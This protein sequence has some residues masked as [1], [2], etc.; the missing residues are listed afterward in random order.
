MLFHAKFV[1]PPLFQFINQNKG[2]SRR[3]QIFFWA[4]DF[5]GTQTYLRAGS[6][7]QKNAHSKP[8]CTPNQNTSKNIVLCYLLPK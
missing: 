1:Y 8:K 4:P 6:G 5:L 2:T 7:T 3:E